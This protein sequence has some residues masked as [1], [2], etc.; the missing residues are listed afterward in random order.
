M[1]KF[2]VIYHAPLDFMKDMANTTPEDRKKGM[3]EWMVW[4]EKCGSKLVDMGAPL[5]NGQQLIPDGTSKSSDKNVVGYSILDAEDLEKAKG[6]L[7]GHPHLAW[8]AQCSIEVH[9]TMPMP[10]M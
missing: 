5:M 9:E 2:I 7:K 6:L 10:G 4:A 1:K 8:N 3:E